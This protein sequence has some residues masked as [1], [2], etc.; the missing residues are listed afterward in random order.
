MIASAQESGPELAPWPYTR[1]LGDDCN[2][3]CTQQDSGDYGGEKPRAPYRADLRGRFFCHISQV[4]NADERSCEK[5][6]STEGL[7]FRLEIVAVRRYPAL[8]T[9]SLDF[10]H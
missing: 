9:E 5:D 4:P 3:N 6:I 1:V 8:S 2:G 7:I 10:S